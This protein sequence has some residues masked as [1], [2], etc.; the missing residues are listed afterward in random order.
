MTIKIKL[1][2]DSAILPHRATPDEAG[3][4]VCYDGEPYTLLPYQRHLFT[5][6]IAMQ[7]P[8]GT[9]TKVEPRSKLA[10]KFGIDV[11][12]GIID[13]NYRGGIGVILRNTGDKEITFKRGDAIAQLVTY[14]IEVEP[15][16]VVDELDESERGTKG[17]NCDDLRLQR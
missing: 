8:R 6:N 1:L 14:K 10:N 5:T 9:F 3:L 4:D 16:E 11:M 2:S 17:V 13:C 15:F 7:T 12:G